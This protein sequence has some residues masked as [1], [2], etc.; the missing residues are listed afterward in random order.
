LDGRNN[1]GDTAMVS[2]TALGTIQ[3]FLCVAVVAAWGVLLPIAG[4]RLR[5]HLRQAHPKVWRKFDFPTESFDVPPEHEYANAIADVG[6]IE[7]FSTGQFKK[8]D[9]QRLNEFYG[10][11]K[12]M[13]WIGVLATVLLAFNFVA[14]HAAPDFSWLL[15]WKGDHPVKTD[16]DAH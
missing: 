7:F 8:L 14:F 9:D 15:V 1:G 4:F 10:R 2:V 13:R 5:R 3:S 11:V 6:F 16:G 12:A